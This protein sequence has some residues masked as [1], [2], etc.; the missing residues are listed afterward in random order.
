MFIEIYDF[1]VYAYVAPILG[2]VLFPPTKT[3]IVAMLNAL[4]V[5]GVGYVMRPIGAIIFGHIADKVGRKTAFIL[6]LLL[7]GL[8]SLGIGFLPTYAVIGVWA[9]VLLVLFRLLQGLGLGGEF[10]S[11]T[12]YII[13]HAP[14]NRR[15]LY[16]SIIQ[17]MWPL[18]F[19]FSVSTVYLVSTIIGSEGLYAW[20]WRIPFWLGAII[21]I[22][23]IIMRFKL[24]ETP[25]FHA[26]ASAGKISKI[27]LVDAFRKA[28][29]PFIIV[30]LLQIAE[31]AIFYSSFLTTYTFW[32]QVSKVP[33]VTTLFSFVLIY[34]IT[35][36]F[37]I[38]GGILS[39]RY[40]RRAIFRLAYTLATITVIPSFYVFT[41]T[42]NVI[43]LS[44]VTLE[45]I[46][47]A[48]LGNAA[49]GAAYPELVPANVRTTGFNL[50]YQISTGIYGGFIPYISLYF[51]YVTHSAALSVLY[52]AISTLI[53]AIVAW[54]WLPETKGVD[55][56]RTV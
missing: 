28:W 21:I 2:K 46:L 25:V 55:L 18:G 7:M 53:G 30:L 36:F 47:Y 54:I 37:Y 56:S 43:I 42:N 27:P 16:A 9:T 44:L 11:A 49:L 6:T 38:A 15:A 50:A 26:Y 48:A 22:V 14:F 4:L 20:G 41:I 12:T 31:T 52:V 29:K 45:L 3:P 24:E 32:L 33:Y 1:V 51:L 39:D 17:A 10:G 8:A 19:A 13:E 35:I 5:F 40:G 34:I 23:G